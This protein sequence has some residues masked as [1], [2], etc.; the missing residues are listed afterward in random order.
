MHGHRLHLVQGTKEEPEDIRKREK[1][2]RK[3]SSRCS[4]S[5]TCPT[6]HRNVPS[7][8]REAISQQS[9]R[10][11][12]TRLSASDRSHRLLLTSS[13]SSSMR[14]G[15][16]LNPRSEYVR[17]LIRSSR[18][19]T[20]LSLKKTCCLTRLPIANLITTPRSKP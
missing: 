12:S 8:T 14:A 13:S 3:R 7:L 4:I 20:W 19:M 1:R 10:G 17:K 6:A 5:S 9:T 15:T 16:V 18:V 2:R 11:P